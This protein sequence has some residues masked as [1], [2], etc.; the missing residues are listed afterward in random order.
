MTAYYDGNAIFGAAVRCNHGPQPADQQTNAY[1]GVSG[2]QSVYGGARGRQFHIE[3]VLT[4]ES[5]GDL[6]AAEQ[7]LLSY[8]DGIGRTLTDTWGTNW[9]NVVFRGQYTRHGMVGFIFG[10]DGSVLFGQAYRA[11]FIGLI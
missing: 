6:A 2:Q 7:L 10:G 5:L 4:G 3:G 11:V 1:F 8:N 9:T